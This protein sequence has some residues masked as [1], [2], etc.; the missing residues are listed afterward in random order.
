ML[1]RARVDQHEAEVEEQRGA[2]GAGVRPAAGDVHG[3]HDRG[4]PPVPLHRVQ[5]IEGAD[6]VGGS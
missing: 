1:D 4:E 5:R 6:A 3:G 2:V